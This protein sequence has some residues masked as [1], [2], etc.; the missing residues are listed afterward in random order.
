MFSSIRFYQFL[1]VILMS[2][3][4]FNPIKT[5]SQNTIFV[6]HRGAS[7]L[8][9]ENTVAAYELAWELGAGAAECD[10]MLTKDKRVILFHDKNGKR[11]TGHNFVV[12]ESN[13]DEI[14]E[15]PILL[16]KTN[17][18]KYKGETIPLLS[19]VLSTVPD[20]STLVIEIKTGP[21]I[22]SYMQ[23][24]I[25]KHWKSGNIAFIAFD[26]E[27][28]LATKEMYPDIPCYYLSAFR[29]DIN[30]KYKKIRESNLDGVNLRHK[31]ISK[32]LVEKYKKIGKDIWSWTV[33][34]PSNAQRMISLGI[35]A[36]TT[37]R[38]AWLPEQLSW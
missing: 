35:S 8:A 34:E 25:S 23:E 14:K 12:K 6:G 2:V 24:V 32:R 21:E 1:S 18:K 10:I 26:F 15:Y 16:S 17:D 3:I 20:N 28:I 9:P 30:S 11:L 31:I 38:P 19:E 36:I 4:L 27:T 13:Y 22:L 33:N 5:Y 37:D 29:I 7:Y